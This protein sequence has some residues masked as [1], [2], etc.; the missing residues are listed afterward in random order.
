MELRKSGFDIS[1]PYRECPVIPG[2][3]IG[4]GRGIELEEDTVPELTGLGPGGGLMVFSD[5][6]DT[7]PE[8]EENGLGREGWF[9]IVHLVADDIEVIPVEGYVRTEGDVPVSLIPVEL[10]DLEIEAR[11]SGHLDKLVIGRDVELFPGTVELT[12][13]PSDKAAVEL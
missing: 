5:L 4:G 9:G 7:V 2:E 6:F 3:V 13:S 10:H 1:G 11:K 12:P 8:P